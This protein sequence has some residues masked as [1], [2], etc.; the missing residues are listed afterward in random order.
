MNNMR[1]TYKKVLNRPKKPGWKRTL[2]RYYNLIKSA[3]W[4]QK[5]YRFLSTSINSELL[6]HEIFSHQTIL[7]RNLTG[8]NRELQKNKLINLK[9]S[10]PWF[11]GL[12]LKP[13]QIFSFWF[14]L[15]KTTY[16]RGFV[17]GMVLRNGEI[18]AEVGGGLCQLSNLIY[19]M[20]LH[21]PLTITERW[22]HGFDVFPD[23]DRTQPFGSGAT[24]AY[25]SIDLKIKND[26][27][28]IFQLKLNL[29]STYL[30]GQWRCEQPIP[31][32]YKVYEQDHRFIPN[33]WGVYLRHNKIYRDIFSKNSGK[34]LATDFIT[35][36]LSRLRYDPLISELKKN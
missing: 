11:N 9:I 24:I 7:L 31:F 21:T 25:P 14:I 34:L 35:E 17:D 20:T 28:F 6:K 2:G 27:S 23:V 22:R 13:G 32:Y 29:I 10:L 30:Q 5:N 4:Q 3:F 18:V 1:L 26:T 33:P 36:N 15:G 8:L 16:C 19:W 12:I